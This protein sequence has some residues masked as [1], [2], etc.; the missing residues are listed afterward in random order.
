M[1]GFYGRILTID[2]SRKE[3]NI[4]PLS[5]ECLEACLGGKGLATRLLLDRNPTGV[6]PLAPQNHLIIATGP[7][8][9]SRLWGGSRYGV[10]TK[11]PLTGFYAESYSGGRVPEAIDSAG[12]DAVLVVGRS[13]AP[14]VVSIHP[15]GAEFHDAGDLWGVD[16]IAA[17]QEALNRFSSNGDGR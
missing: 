8:C 1:F 16:A 2:L 5:D 15:T 12:Y 10:Y 3:F 4:E 6:D 11:S 13:T 17:E 9:Q 7:F 14:T